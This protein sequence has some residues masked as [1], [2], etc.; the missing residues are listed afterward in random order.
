MADLPTRETPPPVRLDPPGRGRIYEN[1]LET[2]GNTPLVRIRKLAR[3]AGVVAD[4]CLKLE[5][6][7]PL[8]SVKDRIGV[9]M[10]EA[11]EQKIMDE[12]QRAFNP[13]FINRLDDIIIFHPLTREQIGQIVRNLLQEVQQRL[14]EERITLKLT[15]EAVSFLID[16]G[17]DEKFG[18][19]PIRRAIQRY[20]E[21]PLSEKLLLAE[22]GPGDEIEVGVSE[23]GKSLSFRALSSSKAG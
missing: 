13:E 15:D 6:F 18:A 7:N 21:D 16:H 20:V 8:A 19:R 3:E 22:F 2:I 9:S 1:V 14:T 10:I 23:D 11:M 12:I 5:F 17:Y 4:L